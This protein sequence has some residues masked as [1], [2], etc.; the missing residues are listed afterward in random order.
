[1]QLP[2]VELSWILKKSDWQSA[3]AENRVMH[4]SE[5]L[6]DLDFSCQQMWKKTIFLIWQLENFYKFVFKSNGIPQLSEL[7]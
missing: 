5:S 6:A 3:T 2:F 4:G 7:C 1:M